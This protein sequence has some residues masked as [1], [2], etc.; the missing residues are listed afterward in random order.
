M[1]SLKQ[2][3][4][5]FYEQNPFYGNIVF[6]DVETTGFSDTDRIIEFGLIAICYNGI[7]V[8][9]LT[10]ETLINPGVLIS[11]KITEVTGITNDDLEFA[12]GDERYSEV[13]EWLNSIKPIKIV[14]HNAKFDERKIKTNLARLGFNELLPPF[15]C[16]MEMAKKKIDLKS[17]KLS[18]VGDHFNYTNRQAH[19]ALADTE[20]CAYVWA[21]MQLQ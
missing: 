19:R 18:S 9:I 13:I 21:K 20:V 17:Y 7:D 12:P 3:F 10:Y 5:Q 8:E 15:E 2:I 1:D 11:N 4:L 6:A 16:T 14:A